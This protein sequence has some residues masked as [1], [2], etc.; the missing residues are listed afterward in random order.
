MST[1]TT[2][3][4]AQSQN[5]LAIRVND[6]VALML[7][8]YDAGDGIM[9]WSVE[10]LYSDGKDDEEE[11][12]FGEGKDVVAVRKAA[13]EALIVAI[14]QEEMNIG[15]QLQTLRTNLMEIRRQ[16]ADMGE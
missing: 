13:Y 15:K 16:R 9:A 12:A 14:E 7:S 5:I 3:V 10:K 1:N 6:S 2:N 11:M 4:T 8:I